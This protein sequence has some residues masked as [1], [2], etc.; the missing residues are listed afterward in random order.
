MIGRGMVA[1]KQG[2]AMFVAVFGYRRFVA[3]GCVRFFGKFLS[4]VQVV[5]V[6]FPYVVGQGDRACGIARWG[7]LDCALMELECAMLATVMLEAVC[8]L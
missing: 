1:C 4:Q 2:Y 6:G 7:E 3:V 8:S 5:Q